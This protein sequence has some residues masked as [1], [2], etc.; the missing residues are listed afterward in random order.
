[1]DEAGVPQGVQ[2]AALRSVYADAE[3]N[4]RTEQQ[5]LYSNSSPAPSSSALGPNVPHSQ[6]HFSII[7]HHQRDMDEAG[8]PQGVQDAALRSFYAALRVTQER[9]N[10]LFRR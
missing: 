4:T 10:S 5:R 9:N 6:A 1:M 7:L 8:V 2:D 3:T